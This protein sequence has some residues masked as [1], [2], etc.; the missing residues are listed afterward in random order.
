MASWPQLKLGEDCGRGHGG[1]PTAPL[2]V[3]FQPT[4]VG[5]ASELEEDV[6]EIGAIPSKI[7][8]KTGTASLVVTLCMSIWVGPRLLL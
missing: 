7:I 4:G 6:G 1:V 5:E 3:Q 8:W 2:D